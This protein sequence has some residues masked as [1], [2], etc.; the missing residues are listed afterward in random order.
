MKTATIR[1]D[2]EWQRAEVHEIIKDT[3]RDDN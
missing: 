2:D 3:E 1:F